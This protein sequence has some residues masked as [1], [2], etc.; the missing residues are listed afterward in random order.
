[1][2]DHDAAA[3]QRAEQESQQR[4]QGGEQREAGHPR[5]CEAEEHDVAGHVGHEHP[6]QAEHAD[7]VHDPGRGGHRQQQCRYG[8]V[9]RPG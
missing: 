2:R 9:H 5:R 6:A 4:G 3:C 7:R 8:P 1:V